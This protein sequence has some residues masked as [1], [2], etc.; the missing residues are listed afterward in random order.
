MQRDLDVGFEHC[1]GAT[2]GRCYSEMRR[3]RDDV[4][5]PQYF[6]QQEADYRPLIVRSTMSSTPHI[7]TNPLLLKVLYHS[8]SIGGMSWHYT[9]PECSNIPGADFTE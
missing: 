4:K 8:R 3:D 6:I 2:S 5:Q 7:P 9:R 1:G